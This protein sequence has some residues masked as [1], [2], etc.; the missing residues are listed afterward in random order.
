MAN[1]AEAKECGL[2]D[3]A[4]T[5]SFDR[6]PCSPV[7]A[8]GSQHEFADASSRKI[9]GHSTENCGVEATSAVGGNHQDLEH[10][11]RVICQLNWQPSFGL[12]V[13]VHVTRNVSESNPCKPG[14]PF[15]LER[16][17]AL[18][19]PRVQEC[20]V[21]IGYL[22]VHAGCVSTDGIGGNRKHLIS[23]WRGRAR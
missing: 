16:N 8:L 23:L 13:V 1:W 14:D 12:S 17:K 7:R 20:K 18:R 5:H 4:E 9:I 15:V 22:I 10:E 21:S 2:T 11:R 19:V 6:S 3:F